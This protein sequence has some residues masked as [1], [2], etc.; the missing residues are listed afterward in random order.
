MRLII[1]SLMIAVS[2]LSM[3]G[4]RKEKLSVLYVGGSANVESIFGDKPAGFE[5]SKKE[6]MENFG[7]F[8]RSRFTKVK[9]IDAD[10][11]TY[12]MS[13]DYD[14]TVMDG[15]PRPKDGGKGGICVSVFPDSFDDAVVCIADVSEYVTRTVGCKNDWYC[16]C[17]NN[18]AH[19]WVKDHPV[20]RGP[21]E[22]ELKTEMRPV[23]ESTRLQQG[24][25][26]KP[27]PDEIETWEVV[28]KSGAPDARIGMVSREDGYTDSPD[29]E[30]IS[31]GECAKPLGAVAIGRHGNFFH[32]GFA[33][34]P[35]SLTE[36]GRDVLANA[37][38]YASKFKGHRIIAR[39]LDEYST[40]RDGFI[41]WIDYS[42]SKDSWMS[43]ERMYEQLRKENPK[44]AAELGD[45]ALPKTYNEYICGKY[46]DLYPVLGPDPK[47]YRRYFEAN[48]E[49]LRPSDDDPFN[50]V[51]DR[52]CREIGVA[53]NNI[54]MLDSAISVWEDGGKRAD[55]GRRLLRRY[56]LCRFDTPGEYREWV[57]KY[58]DKLFFTDAGGFLW[59]VNSR[60]PGVT[61]NDYD[62][63]RREL[64]MRKNGVPAEEK[65]AASVSGSGVKTGR[66]VTSNEEPV[67]L[68]AEV[69][70]GENGDR[71]FKLTM[72]IEPGFH[73][74]AT[75]DPSE[76][77]IQ[78]TVDMVFP[79]GIVP[80]GDVVMP[81]TV[82]TGNGTTLYEGMV[83]FM[84]RFTG[85][86]DG[87]IKANVRYQVCDN[88]GCRIPVNKTVSARL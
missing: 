69:I 19:S 15:T 74:Y 76:S 39:K 43:G 67:A 27:C 8:L 49:Y 3:E 79:D 40:D 50:M 16:L 44:R 35:E 84:R 80:V 34:D 10:K 38:V 78:T 5:K 56:T 64:E 48:R 12:P 73:A 52:D 41:S 88:V 2:A 36:A 29:A 45:V 31:G 62:V 42:L 66:L 54:A 37:I 60:E 59:L 58:R 81:E 87:E 11:Y 17:L 26:G 22:V 51:V 32:W 25:I 13:A 70:N 85:N 4:V 65:P 24:F 18:H 71:Y 83:S 63:L 53:N 68:E 75:V 77:L 21:F 28:R 14:V 46:P 86:G 47:E 6:R 72:L 82:S 57:D 23:T 30:F 7:R 1:L 61:G 20:F 33:A 55:I 9:V